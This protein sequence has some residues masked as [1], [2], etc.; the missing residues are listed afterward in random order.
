MSYGY[1]DV[2]TNFSS[3]V[4]VADEERIIKATYIL[5]QNAGDYPARIENYTLYPGASI[6]VG[7][8]H[9]VGEEEFRLDIHFLQEH[10]KLD[11]AECTPIKRIEFLVRTRVPV[12]CSNCN[13]SGTGKKVR[14]CKICNKQ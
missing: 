9:S 7:S 1:I 2:K 10:V 8:E 13:P 14:T 6:W 5:V 4:T 12:S 11:D 3:R